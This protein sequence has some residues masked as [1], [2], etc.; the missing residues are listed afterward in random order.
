[1]ARIK[2]DDYGIKR[3][4]IL[5]KSAQL[6]AEM[7]YPNTSML[8]IAK[9]C[10]SSKSMLYHYFAK[11][12]DILFSI[13]QEHINDV[14]EDINYILDNEQD[15]VSAFVDIFVQR[16]IKARTRHIVATMDVKYLAEPEQKI[17]KSL[18]R[19]VIALTSNMLR[20]VNPYLS[21]HEYNLYS[22][23]LIGT[24]NSMDSWRKEDGYYTSEEISKRL[25]SVFVNGFPKTKGN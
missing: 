9:A 20:K 11:K 12:E 1:M 6:F 5:D 13:L 3:A 19:Q 15:L 24:I 4:A 18:E 21:A 10:G 25:T 14:I 8:G 16:S 22:L 2:S 23:L 7:G 17:I